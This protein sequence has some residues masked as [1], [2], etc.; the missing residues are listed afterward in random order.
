MLHINCCFLFVSSVVI[1]IILPLIGSNPVQVRNSLISRFK[2]TKYNQMVTS[3][4]IYDYST[5]LQQRHEF[6]IW[7]EFA[8]LLQL[9]FHKNTEIQRKIKLYNLQDECLR[10]I[11]RLPL[12]FGPG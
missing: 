9:P 4:Y 2:R 8:A 12:N 10:I 5:W 6:M 7:L 1:L 11:E 3:C